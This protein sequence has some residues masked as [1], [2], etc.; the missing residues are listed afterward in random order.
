M[1]GVIFRLNKV[2]KKELFMTKP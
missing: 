1:T 2:Q